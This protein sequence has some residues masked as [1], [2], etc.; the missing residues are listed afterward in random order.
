[1]KQRYM[2]DMLVYGNNGG[3]IKSRLVHNLH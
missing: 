3:L 2:K 1:M